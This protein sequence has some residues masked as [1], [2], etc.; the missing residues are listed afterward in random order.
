M[1]MRDRKRRP[2]LFLRC[3]YYVWNVHGYEDETKEHYCTE[4]LLL[5][6]LECMDMRIEKNRPLLFLRCRHFAC[7]EVHGHEDRKRRPLLFLEMQK[8]ETVTVLEMQVLCMSGMCMDMRMKR[9]EHYCTEIR[10]LCMSG[11]CMDMR[12]EKIDRYCS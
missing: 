3:R 1:D 9:K 5:A 6:C 12:I 8:E 7:L 4:I 2:L 10:L 11:V